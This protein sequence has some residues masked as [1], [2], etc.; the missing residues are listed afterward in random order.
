[1]EDYYWFSIFGCW[2]TVIKNSI[3][4]PWSEVMC[5][6]I[7]GCDWWH[8]AMRRKT[9]WLLPPT[10]AVWE[11]KCHGVNDLIFENQSCKMKRGQAVKWLSWSSQF[12]FTCRCEKW[13][14]VGISLVV[15]SVKCPLLLSLMTAVYLQQSVNWV[16]GKSVCMQTQ[17]TCSLC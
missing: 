1:M 14:P 7:A 13:V 9:D 3:A 17:T 5:F 8:T 16:S 12:V 2:N 6:V 15:K 4:V 11:L 10:W